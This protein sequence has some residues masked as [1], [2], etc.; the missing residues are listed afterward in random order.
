MKTGVRLKLETA[1]PINNAM[2]ITVTI[3]SSRVKLCL[4]AAIIAF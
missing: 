2:I 1:T 4:R 3:N